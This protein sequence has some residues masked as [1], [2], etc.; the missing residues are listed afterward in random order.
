[1]L[2]TIEIIADLV[3]MHYRTVLKA[4]VMVVMTMIAVVIFT[5]SYWK[6]TWIGFWVL[7]LSL[8]S[9]WRRYL[10]PLCFAAFVAAVI[11]TCVEPDLLTR[12][13]LALAR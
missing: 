9:T 2:D 7:V 3:E 13:E 1:M 11:F 4:F 6:A 12:L 8:F 5:G 10:E